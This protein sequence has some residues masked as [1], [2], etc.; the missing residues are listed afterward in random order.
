[1]VSGNV[2]VKNPSGLHMRPASLMTQIATKCKSNIIITD[3]LKKV[4]PKSILSLMSAGIKCG[5]EVKVVCEG[6]SEDNDL[7]TIIEAIESGLGEL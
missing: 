3:G 1:M 4:N 6:D 5:A 2:V 7:K